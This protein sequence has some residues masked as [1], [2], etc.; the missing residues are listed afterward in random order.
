MLYFRDRSRDRSRDRD[1]DRDRDRNRDRDQGRRRRSRT[2]RS[3]SRDR[4][5]RDRD[6]DRDRRRDRGRSDSRD[7]DRNRDKE[8]DRDRD[9]DRNRDKDRDKQTPAGGTPPYEPPK[10]STP[11]KSLLPNIE[12]F[13]FTQTILEAMSMANS[14]AAANVAGVTN[15]ITSKNFA[16]LLNGNSNDSFGIS[17]GGG[18]IG[19]GDSKSLGMKIVIYVT[20]YFRLIYR[21]NFRLWQ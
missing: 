15:Q 2:P 14:L 4:D 16:A 19:F 10:S 20:F 9:R 3:R 8:R 21:Y 5:R 13:D 17:D 6:R 11:P 7:R 18:M 12:K 1:R